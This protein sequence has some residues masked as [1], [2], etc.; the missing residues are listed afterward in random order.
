VAP[1]VLFTGLPVD[2]CKEFG[3]AFGDYC[4]AYNGNSNL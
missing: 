2:F 3:L 1:K 4:E